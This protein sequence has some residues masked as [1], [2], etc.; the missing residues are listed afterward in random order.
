M[1]R[2]NK[3]KKMEG[4]YVYLS[5]DSSEKMHPDN[6]K[7]A[8]TVE[9]ATPIELDP[10]YEWYVALCEAIF[11]NVI[12]RLYTG[13]SVTNVNKGPIF[14]YTDLVRTSSVGDSDNKLLRIISLPRAHQTF[15]DRFY[16]PVVRERI[17]QISVLMTDRRGDKY[18]LSTN[19]T[20]VVLVLHF[21]H[22]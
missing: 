15:T 22:K 12:D 2:K 7:T 3:Y 18:P 16:I 9:L 19:T 13:I 17:N 20:P 1:A 21:N 14:V 11:P 4:F 8:F 10:K 5:S 6:K